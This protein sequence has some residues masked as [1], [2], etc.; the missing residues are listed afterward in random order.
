M[1]SRPF[2][3]SDDTGRVAQTEESCYRP[4]F[5]VRT[6]GGQRSI[7]VWEMALQS[8]AMLGNVHRHREGTTLH[9]PKEVC[10]KCAV[11]FDPMCANL[12]LFNTTPKRFRAG[13]V[14]GKPLIL[15]R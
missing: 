14:V 2:R 5:P 4:F 7:S 6:T 10:H 13:L 12:R 8:C 1:R 9:H 15:P 11:L 3:H